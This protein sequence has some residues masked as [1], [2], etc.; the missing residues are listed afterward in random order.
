MIIYV[1]TLFIS[2]TTYEKYYNTALKYF[3][4][5]IA[6]TFFNEELGY[7]VRTYDEISFFQNI[8]Y[9][10][11]ND[12]IYNIYAIIFFCFFYFVYR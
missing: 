6:Y 12:V 8:K 5:I 10:N 3:P 4:I 7:L 11:F 9:S 1:D 2:L